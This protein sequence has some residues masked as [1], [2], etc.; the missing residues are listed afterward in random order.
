MNARLPEFATAALLAMAHSIMKTQ[1]SQILGDYGEDYL[2][3]WFLEKEETGSIYIHH[4]LRSDYD[5]EMH[6]HPGD[7][8]SIVLSGTI[9]E[10]SPEGTRVLTAGDIV[11]RKAT[12]KHKLEID[13]PAITMWI[14]GERVREWGFWDTDGTFTPS[15]EFFKRRSTK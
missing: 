3:R 5:D 1:P 6:D 10:Y 4:I 14:M 11:S 13:S 9:K 12:D 8:L 15:T 2:H 7:N